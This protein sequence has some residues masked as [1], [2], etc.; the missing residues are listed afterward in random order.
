[1]YMKRLFFFVICLMF[2]TL[3]IKV[4]ASEVNLYLF[5][6]K[7]CPHCEEEMAFFDTYLKDK[8]NVKLY[9]YEVWHDKENVE[10]MTKAAESIGIKVDGSVPFLIIGNKTFVGF[11][12]SYTPEQVDEYINCYS[13]Y[14]YRDMVG[15]T[16]GVVTPDGSKKV[17]NN[18]LTYGKKDKDTKKEKK[19]EDKKK[20]EEKTVPILGKINAKTVSLPLLATVMGFVDG[21]NPCAMWILIFLITMLIGMKDRKKM[22]ALGL[23][24]LI[25]SSLVYTL[26]MVSWLSVAVFV[27]KIT[28]IRALIAIFAIIFGGYNLYN[29]Y[30]HRNDDDGCEVVDEQYRKKT[31]K[32]IKRIVTDKRFL[33]S[34]LG[35]IVLA[36]SVNIIELMCSLG[37]PVVF[38]Q[39][40]SLN[41]LSTGEYALMIFIYIFFFMLDDLIVFFIAMKSLK[42]AAISNKYTKYSHLIGGIIMMLLGILMIVKPAWLMFNF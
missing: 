17:I 28:I 24:F 19:K 20:E 33:F 34:I 36:A 9:K 27:N 25:T 3:P 39:V 16:L 5:Y 6:G 22:W 8:D 31:I 23:T 38:T 40:L 35:I 12:S 41:D 10:K 42:I 18:C 1:M 11:N 4:N 2:L 29:Y 37:L 13:K 30:K 15:E 7:E 14:D 32:R 21:F 26:F